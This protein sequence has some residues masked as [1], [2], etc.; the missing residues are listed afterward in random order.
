MPPARQGQRCLL[1]SE[2]LAMAMALQIERAKPASSVRERACCECARVW[3]ILHGR[4]RERACVAVS[5]YEC[6]RARVCACASVRGR[7]F[8]WLLHLIVIAECERHG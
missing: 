6:T 1:A 5:A 2:V 8:V 4:F 7:A 3:A